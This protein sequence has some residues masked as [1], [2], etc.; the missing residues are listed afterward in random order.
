[1]RTDLL[2][3]DFVLKAAR[4]EAV[5]LYD[6]AARRNFVHVRDVADAI[7]WAIDPPR[8]IWKGLPSAERIFNLGNDEA[9]ITKRGLCEAIRTRVPGFR[10]F[11]VE[12]RDPDARDYLVSN[13]RLAAAGFR[14]RRGL[15]EGIDEL[16]KLYAAFPRHQWGNV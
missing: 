5:A 2:V 15:V 4:G 10:W 6:G 3:N 13:K 9:N 1:M 11:E 7:L 12:G 8:V 14:A 16:L